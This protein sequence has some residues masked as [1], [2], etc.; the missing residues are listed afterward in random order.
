MP[1]VSSMQISYQHNLA[2]CATRLIPLPPILHTRAD[3]M[4]PIMTS[5]STHTTQKTLPS[6]IRPTALR[7]KETKTQ[8]SGSSENKDSTEGTL[9]VEGILV[10]EGVIEAEETLKRE[11]AFE[12][13]GVHEV[14]QNLR[15]EEVHGHLLLTNQF[16]STYLPL[17]KKS[18][19]PVNQRIHS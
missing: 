13:K 18:T 14:E 17:S 8:Q 10:A 9:E 2:L 4:I 15:A 12:A 19:L 7:T 5:A 6:C 1:L 16:D 11:E 3:V